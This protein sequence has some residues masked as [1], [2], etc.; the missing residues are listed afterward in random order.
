M[1]FQVGLVFAVAGLAF[2]HSLEPGHA[3]PDAGIWA[4]NHE[5]S[6]RSGVESGLMLSLGHILFPALASQCLYCQ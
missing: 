3:W 1:A 2:L 5:N 6:Y 4:S